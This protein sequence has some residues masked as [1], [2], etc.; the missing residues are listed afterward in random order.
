MR[1]GGRVFFGGAFM[2]V[3]FAVSSPAW[4]NT[5]LATDQGYP[6]ATT[7]PVA[8]GPSGQPSQPSQA[9]VLGHTSPLRSGVMGARKTV[10]PSAV[11]PR[12]VAKP[13]AQRPSATSGVLGVTHAVAPLPFTGLQLGV[14]LLIALALIACGL[15]LRLSG[16]SRSS[17]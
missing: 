17:A 16:R 9:A 1:R 4:G 15:L 12:A 11:A 13:A 8:P 6:S 10:A 2:L 3:V 7:P 14:F 5:G